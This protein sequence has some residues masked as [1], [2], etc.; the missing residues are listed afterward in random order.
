MFKSRKCVRQAQRKILFYSRANKIFLKKKMT[1]GKGTSLRIMIW[2]CFFIK[3]GVIK[4]KSTI[5]EYFQYA[6]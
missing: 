5:K 1:T 2:I 3:K 6:L 4:K